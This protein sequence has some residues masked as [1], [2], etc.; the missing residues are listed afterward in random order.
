MLL[1]YSNVYIL[2]MFLVYMAKD[3]WDLAPILGNVF[4]ED[5]EDK[6]IVDAVI[7]AKKKSVL[8]N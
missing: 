2:P 5:E 1:L 7:E 6:K 4:I 8:K 3:D